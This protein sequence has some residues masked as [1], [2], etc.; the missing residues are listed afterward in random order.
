MR[1]PSWS[2]HRTRVRT[3][4]QQL[5]VVAH[6]LTTWSLVGLIWTVQVVVYPSFRHVPPAAFG[7][8]HQGHLRRIT[9]V[10]APLM[11][12]ELALA[13]M[14]FLWRPP[15]VSLVVSAIGLGLL[16]CIWASTAFIQVPLHDRIGRRPIPSGVVRLT[17]S[18]WVRT[19]AWTLRGGLAA[20]TLASPG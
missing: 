8:Y 13:G 10:V 6:A 5:L 18:N 12:L 1:R 20:W 4:A 2:K 17:T 3:D 14:L 7:P 19:A 15:G 16:G 9:Q 11:T